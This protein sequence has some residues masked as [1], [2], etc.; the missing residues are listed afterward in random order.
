L[1][2]ANHL[3][4][5]ASRRV[6]HIAFAG[7]LDGATVH[8][9]LYLILYHKVGNETNL[10]CHDRPGHPGGMQSRAYGINKRGQ[11]VGASVAASEL[12]RAFLWE[13]GVMTDLGTLGR[14]WSEAHGV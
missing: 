12:A 2:P 11:V 4:V 7:A 13:D 1:G 6:R 5:G 3:W 9:T 14:R 10:K 8:G